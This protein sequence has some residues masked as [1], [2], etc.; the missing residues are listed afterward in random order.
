MTEAGGAHSWLIPRRMVV[1][2]VLIGVAL[3]VPIAAAWMLGGPG[4]A[5]LVGL[6]YGAAVP[7]AVAL[8]TGRAVS[9]TVPAAM[10]A[11]VAVAIGPVPLPAAC[12]VALLVLFTIPGSPLGGTA[13]VG[14]P[15]TAAVLVALP[16][17]VDPV[18]V[19]LWTLLGGAAVVLLLGLF[20]R[21]RPVPAATPDANRSLLHAVVSAIAVGLAIWVV[22]EFQ[23]PHGYWSAMTLTLVLR[24]VREDTS[25]TARRRVVGTM[26]G[27][28]LALFLA[29]VLPTWAAAVLLGV[30]LVG[31]VGY[32]LARNYTMQV[33]CLTPMIILL[34][35]ASGGAAQLAAE[36]VLATVAGALAA[37]GVGAVVLWLEN[38]LDRGPEA[39]A[40]LSDGSGMAGW[41]A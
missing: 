33:A 24:R 20:T 5:L 36:R 13:L 19:G 40:G 21:G 31:V 22:L 41:P 14:I 10:V 25:S 37:G 35:S 16:V 18:Q 32:A 6:G 7:L 39:K 28:L 30:L 15:T 1:P 34:G 8:P 12:L 26:L 4:A 29:L 38:R 3:L 9:L 2:S 11:V 27:A 17:R 23:V